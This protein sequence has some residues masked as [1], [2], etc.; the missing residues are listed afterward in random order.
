MASFRK[1]GQTW[2]AELYVDGQ[3]DSRTFRTKAEAVAWANMREAELTGKALPDHTLHDALRRYAREVAP[4]HKG[5]RWEIVRC[6]KMEGHRIAGKRLAALTA[7]DLSAWR[8]ERLRDVSG[9]S[10]RREMTLLR[11]VLEVARREWGWLRVNPLGDVKRPASPASRKRRISQDEIERITLALGYD[12]GVPQNASQRVALA[13]LFAIETAM[14]SGEIVGLRWQDLGDKLARLPM[15]KNGDAREVPLNAEA[16]EI[17]D[18]LPRDSEL[19][20]NL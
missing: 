16:R 18:L 20:F 14:R 12:G 4:T 1:R 19:V 2:R 8:D 9:A 15:T 13:F 3:R 11:S 17:I 7:A 10:V 6:R 5:E